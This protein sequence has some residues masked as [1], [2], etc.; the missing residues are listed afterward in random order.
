M[1]P[2][3]PTGMS[4]ALQMTT[5]E[6]RDGIASPSGPAPEDASD[7][8]E[9]DDRLA[10]VGG[11]DP[12]AVAAELVEI[13]GVRRLAELQHDV[14]GGIDDAVDRPH[15]GQGQPPLQPRR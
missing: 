7:A 15:A 10:R 4:L 2:P 6:S 1:M 11:P 8:V 3:M 12:K 9:G 13:V 14:V 5:V